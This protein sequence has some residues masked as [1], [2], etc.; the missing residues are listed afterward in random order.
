MRSRRFLVP[1]DSP[2]VLR[3]E[4]LVDLADCPP[5]GATAKQPQPDPLLD[6]V[7]GMALGGRAPHGR[8]VLYLVSDDN[9]SAAQTTRVYALAVRVRA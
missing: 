4:P 9:G 2:A 7:E 6:N 5:S 3:K 1:A 8:R